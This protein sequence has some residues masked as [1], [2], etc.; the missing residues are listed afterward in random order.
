MARFDPNEQAECSGARG[1]QH[2]RRCGLRWGNL[3]WRNDW[4]A[5][6]GRI[7]LAP[8]RS[9]LLEADIDIWAFV[10]GVLLGPRPAGRGSGARSL[11]CFKSC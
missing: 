7:V 3:G 1:C 11:T 6:T 2:L 5:H 9:F 10:Q 4:A 8:V